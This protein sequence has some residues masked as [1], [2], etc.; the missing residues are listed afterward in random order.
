[1]ADLHLCCVVPKA[2][3]KVHKVDDVRFAHESISNKFACGHSF[4]E[5]IKDSNRGRL[6]PLR[7]RLMNL[8]MIAWPGNG[9]FALNNR[10][11]FCLQ[12]HQHVLGS[13]H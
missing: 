5:L 6:Q 8:E 9:L 3:V 2:I 12:R 7:Q 13:R 4:D 1:M 11:L 10:R